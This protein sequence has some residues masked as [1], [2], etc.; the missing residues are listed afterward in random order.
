MPTQN[1]KAQYSSSS[2][3]KPVLSHRKAFTLSPQ[4]YIF[5]LK[6]QLPKWMREHRHEI[7]RPYPEHMLFLTRLI[8]YLGHEIKWECTDIYRGKNKWLFYC[9]NSY[10]RLNNKTS[11]HVCHSPFFKFVP[12]LSCLNF[13]AYF[14]SRNYFC[15]F[16][17]RDFYWSHFLKWNQIPTCSVFTVGCNFYLLLSC[18]FSLFAYHAKDLVDGWKTWSV[19]LLPADKQIQAV[20]FSLSQYHTP[21]IIHWT[22][23]SNKVGFKSSPFKDELQGQNS[24]QLLPADNCSSSLPCN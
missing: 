24:V 22:N 10:S 18:I 4:H 20:P 13:T 8:I 11:V 2:T 16:K 15:F 19:F 14:S 6:P 3:W 21:E 12:L 7:Y 23:W 17:Q 1:S 5:H 9:S